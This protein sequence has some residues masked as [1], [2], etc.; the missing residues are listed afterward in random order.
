MRWWRWRWRWM[1][2]I[3][4]VLVVVSGLDAKEANGPDED[5]GK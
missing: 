4:L 1:G 3:A 5:E 2:L